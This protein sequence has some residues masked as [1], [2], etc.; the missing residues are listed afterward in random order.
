MTKKSNITKKSE[1]MDRNN[2]ILEEV[3][4]NLRKVEEEAVEIHRKIS[5]L[6]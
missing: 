4:N 3:S 6:L 2:K 1:L 5:L